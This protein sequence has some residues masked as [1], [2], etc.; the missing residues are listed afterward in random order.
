MDESRGV[1]MCAHIE[2][3]G[4]AMRTADD[5]TLA[6]MAD[7]IISAIERAEIVASMGVRN[8]RFR[9]VEIDG[10]H[11]CAGFAMIGTLARTLELTPKVVR[12]LHEQERDL[13]G[14][15]TAWAASVQSVDELFPDQAA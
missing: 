13:L 1:R 9:L 10:Q 7:G 12:K 15:E 14:I 3:T 8:R 5:V 4:T 11:V 6:A 2:E